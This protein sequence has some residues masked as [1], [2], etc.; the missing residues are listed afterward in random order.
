M[1]PKMETIK[2]THHST[3]ITPNYINILMHGGASALHTIMDEWC[4][5]MVST[6]C[7]REPQPSLLHCLMCPVT[8]VKTVIIFMPNVNY[9]ISFWPAAPGRCSIQYRLSEH[10]HTTLTTGVRLSI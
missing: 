8:T 4:D 3:D 5:V 10:H 9:S 1:L 7:C 6:P 2:Y